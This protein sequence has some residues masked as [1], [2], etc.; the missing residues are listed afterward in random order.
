MLYAFGAVEKGPISQSKQAE[1]TRDLKSAVNPIWV[2]VE[3]LPASKSNSQIL[4]AA[5]MLLSDLRC[6]RQ[7]VKPSKW[8]R[9]G[10]KSV[11]HIHSSTQEALTPISSDLS[12]INAIK[13][14][15]LPGLCCTM[16]AIFIRS[17]WDAFTKFR[18]SMSWSFS[19]NY[20]LLIEMF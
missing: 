15:K 18:R 3:K 6:E 7:A 12:T 19:Y 8:G 9:M 10:A 11:L 20:L 14:P 16:E 2:S 13:T 17:C 1:I 4:A 5:L